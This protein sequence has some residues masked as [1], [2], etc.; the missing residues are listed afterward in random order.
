MIRINCQNNVAQSRIM[1]INIAAPDLSRI[2]RLIYYIVRFL[3]FISERPLSLFLGRISQK[4]Q[5]TDSVSNAF[6]TVF[7]NNNAALLDETL[8]LPG[9]L[10]SRTLQK[11]PLNQ[12]IHQVNQDIGRMKIYVDGKRYSDIETLQQK[13]ANCNASS[14]LA[15]CQQTLIAD[16]TIPH[17]NPIVHPEISLS[18][19]SRD[20]SISQR[21]FIEVRIETNS[22]GFIA[23]IT[24][25]MHFQGR[26]SNEA[27]TTFSRF[28][29]HATLNQD[30]NGFVH[31]IPE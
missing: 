31:W 2:D 21:N 15:L 29:I 4:P 12:N 3:T 6:S 16:F 14:A 17:E 30:G 11:V 8:I 26:T 9:R 7:S 19:S 5:Y 20:I 1:A 22:A 23:Q 10:Q 27:V 25:P 13:L 28:T 18:L 24:V